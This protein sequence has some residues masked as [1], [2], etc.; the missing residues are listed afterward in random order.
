MKFC[1]QCEN[2]LY[3]SQL[4]STKLVYMCKYCGHTQ[5]AQTDE[6]NI[7]EVSLKS[8]EDTQYLINE[9]TKY[10]MTLPRIQDMDCPNMEC[11]SRKNTK[12]KDIIYIRYNE[13]DMKYLYLCG[14]CNHHWK[15]NKNL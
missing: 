10:D 2:M 4:T 5:D 12:E 3:L 15:L 13:E 11:P 9:Y 14:V 1:P 6:L 7:F 8:S